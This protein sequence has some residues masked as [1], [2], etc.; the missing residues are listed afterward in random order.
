[1]LLILMHE[2]GKQILIKIFPEEEKTSFVYVYYFHFFGVFLPSIW[3][4]YKLC[5][6]GL[7]AV[8]LGLIIYKVKQKTFIKLHDKWSSPSLSTFW[9]WHWSNGPYRF[10]FMIFFLNAWL[11]INVF[12]LFPNSAKRRKK[13]VLPYFLSN[14]HQGCWRWWG[15]KVSRY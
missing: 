5:Q 3:Y 13:L 7:P 6:K 8:M 9:Q 1:M 10:F 12:N 11:P 15:S 14:F 4:S 2:I